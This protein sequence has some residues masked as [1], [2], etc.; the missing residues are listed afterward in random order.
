MPLNSASVNC[1]S[2]STFSL[3]NFFSSSPFALRSLISKSNNL[4]CSLRFSFDF[5]NTFSAED[6][7]AAIALSIRS[8]SSL[9]YFAPLAISQNA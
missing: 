3:V 4:N 5:A 6:V 7:P 8:F 1:F 9:A 2:R